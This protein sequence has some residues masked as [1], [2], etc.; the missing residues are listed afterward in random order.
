MTL[1]LE[2]VV[3]RV[4]AET[5][6]YNIDLALEPGTLYVLL[7]PTLAGKTSL[8]RLFAG[9][10]RP[11]SGRLLRDG[12]DI[13]GTSVRKRGVAMVYQQFINYPSFT[14]YDNIASPLRRGGAPRDTI[15]ARV[16]EVAAMLHIDELLDRLPAELSGG[17]QQRTALARALARDS[18]LLLLDE[19][20]VNLDY[21]LREEL[22]VELKAI[23]RTGRAT[24]VYATTEPM[25]ALMLGGQTIVLD[26]GRVLQTGPTIEVFHRPQ[27]LRVGQVFSD[28]P[29]NVIDGRVEGGRALLGDSLAVPLAGHLANLAPGP[30]RFGVRASHLALTR[31][32]DDAI[33]FSGTVELAEIS[34]SETFIHV[35]HSGIIWVV[36][37]AGVHPLKL[38]ERRSVFVDP[39]SLFAFDPEGALVAAPARAG[40]TLAAQ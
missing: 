24:V 15:D 19:P 10:D 26:A 35:A 6:L 29:M 11:T 4:G 27:S 14:V 21:K 32:A 5:H 9:L 28:P 13:T 20:L 40:A 17:Q 3:K 33:E 22:R 31:R 16:R 39:G 23:F 8:I 7:G 37:E 34:G 1:A 2:G 12:R 30:Y 36:Q 25:E 38:G 18:D